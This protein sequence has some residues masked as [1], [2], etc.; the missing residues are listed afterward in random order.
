M[1]D[2]TYEELQQKIEELR[3]QAQEIL[4]REQDEAI[5]T[6]R[7]LIS[8]FGL[9]PAQCGFSTKFP[10]STAPKRVI[11]A[12]VYKNP[13]TGETVSVQQGRRPSWLTALSPEELA[14]ARIS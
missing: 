7:M 5:G 4:K 6:V 11:P 1:S 10:K 14:H 8:K 2:M 13:H 9:T 12:G 3:A